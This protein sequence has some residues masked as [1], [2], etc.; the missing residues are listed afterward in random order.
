MRL[1]VSGSNHG[2]FVDRKK[3][4]RKN[5]HEYTKFTIFWDP[6]I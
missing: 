5:P 6:K 2:W 1:S 3:S 4:S